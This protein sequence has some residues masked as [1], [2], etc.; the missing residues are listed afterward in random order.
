MSDAPRLNVTDLAATVVCMDWIG[1]TDGGLYRGFHGKVSVYSAQDAVGFEPTGHNS[2]NW[3]ARV[4]GPT[5]AVTL[6]GCQVR[7]FIEG[8][9][10]TTREFLILP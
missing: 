7:A 2:A 6:M 3:F 8:P 10:P 4:V 1:Y 9:A 5:S